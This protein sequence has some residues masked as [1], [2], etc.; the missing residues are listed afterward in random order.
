MGL[1]VPSTA[2]RSIISAR[3]R[4][5]ATETGNPTY[6]IVRTK[7]G[8]RLEHGR[9][10]TGI[11]AAIEANNKGNIIGTWALNKV[12]DS[13]GDYF[14]IEYIEVEVGGEYRPSRIKYTG[15]DAAGVLPY[16]SVTFGYE[17]RPDPSA[18]FI[19]DYS[20]HERAHDVDCDPSRPNHGAR[21]QPVLSSD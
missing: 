3:L 12:I 4:H 5:G 16:A 10:P 8:E 11:D 19:A 15:N 2:P 1:L 20:R 6:F 13:A 18:G 9:T 7:S 21:V 14:E 17:P